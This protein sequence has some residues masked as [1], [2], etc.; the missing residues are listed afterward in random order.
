MA[1]G[2]TRDGAVKGVMTGLFRDVG[3]G[4]G[5]PAAGESMLCTQAGVA[6]AIPAGAPAEAARLM[7]L[8][9]DARAP[10]LI[11]GKITE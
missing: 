8:D 6:A 10:A 9:P 7:G 4:K 1:G 11:D 5:A 2:W 3:E